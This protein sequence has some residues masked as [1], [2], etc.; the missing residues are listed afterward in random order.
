MLFKRGVDAA[1]ASR[2]TWFAMG[3]LAAL[4]HLVAGK[5]LTVTSVAD[6]THGPRSK[7]YSGEAFDTRVRDLD[8]TEREAIIAAAREILNPRGYD[9]IS[10]ET[11]GHADHDHI[12]YDP[13]AGEEWV[14]EIA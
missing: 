7:H 9:V 14:G 8:P 5:R 2:E 6:G 11:A 3:V 1:K 10:K 13:K 12:E 4:Y